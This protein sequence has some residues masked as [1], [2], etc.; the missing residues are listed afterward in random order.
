MNPKPRRGDSLDDTTSRCMRETAATTYR[1][2]VPDSKIN[3]GPMWHA[4]GMGPT[5][6]KNRL[7]CAGGDYSPRKWPELAAFVFVHPIAMERVPKP[8]GHPRRR[9]RP[10]F[11]I[12]RIENNQVGAHFLEVVNN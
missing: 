8:D 5:K 10:R 6:T 2:S 11:E 12:L 4:T 7:E 3:A 9:D 1:T